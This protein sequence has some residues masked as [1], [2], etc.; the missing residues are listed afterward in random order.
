MTVY[1]DDMEAPLGRM[2]MCHM[3]ADTRAELLGMVDTVGVQRKWIQQR[4]SAQ[5][6][7]DISKAKRALAVKAGA[8]EVT[9]VELAEITYGRRG[10]A[11]KARYLEREP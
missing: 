8:A 4:G 9:M 3:V 7:F 5:E 1:V 2:L 6:H 11:G 10:S